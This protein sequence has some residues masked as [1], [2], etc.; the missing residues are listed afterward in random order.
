MERTV[1]HS[2]GI[3]EGLKQGDQFCVS[4]SYFLYLQDGE[5][6]VPYD[7][8]IQEQLSSVLLSVLQV[9]GSIIKP[10]HNA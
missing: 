1:P 5:A 2:W 6:L 8:D 7:G 3:D 9:V 4:L 10:A